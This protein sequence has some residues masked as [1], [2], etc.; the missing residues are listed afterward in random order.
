MSSA[1]QHRS[2]VVG[3]DGSR[4]G[5]VAVEHAA[6]MAGADGC[7]VLVHAHDLPGDWVGR[8]DYQQALN[9]EAERGRGILE[10]AEALLA[11]ATRS[12]RE[13]IGGNPA[14]ALA[15]IAA[16]RG[17][18]A[19]VIGTRGFGRYRALLGSVAHELIH[20]AECPVVV[21]PERVVERAEA[22]TLLTV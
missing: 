9:R 5:Y 15:R 10:A 20:L 14:E 3:V 16:V 13:E 18:E 2:I 7:V 12:E 4:A 8:P 22:Q 21:I 17:A 11:P 19:I 1:D 6:T